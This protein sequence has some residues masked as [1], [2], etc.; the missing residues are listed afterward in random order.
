[1][2][3][4]IVTVDGG[5]IGLPGVLEHVETVTVSRSVFVV[6]KVWPGAVEY[7][8]IVTSSVFVAYEVWV[9]P[10][11]C[12]Q[13]GF[14]NSNARIQEPTCISCSEGRHMVL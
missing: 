5:M 14:H 10:A 3:E 8:V 2:Y 7:C 1:M 6:Y 13:F 12:Q 9:V 11:G 4:V